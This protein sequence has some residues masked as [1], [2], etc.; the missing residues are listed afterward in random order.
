MPAAF[1]GYPYR[2]R[3]KYL[4][5]ISLV[6]TL[7]GGITYAISQPS[8]KCQ[9]A[10]EIANGSWNSAD[11]AEQLTSD[12]FISEIFGGV[13]SPDWEYRYSK[14]LLELRRVAHLYKVYAIKWTLENQECFSETEIKNAQIQAQVQK[15]FEAYF[16]E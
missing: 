9:S 14:S 15:S 10:R 1:Q 12:L 3:R 7:A 5:Y 11:T 6:L 4:I 13:Q 16:A 8:I 2:M